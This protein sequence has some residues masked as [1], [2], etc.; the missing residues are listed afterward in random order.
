M[1]TLSGFVNC[2]VSCSMLE[3]KLC[4]SVLE[5]D[6]V[7]ELVH[8]YIIRKYTDDWKGNWSKQ[9]LFHTSFD[10][11]IIGDIEYCI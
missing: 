4:M 9:Y 6:T 8:S 7:V 11:K 5:L 1:G 3:V 10:G 2:E